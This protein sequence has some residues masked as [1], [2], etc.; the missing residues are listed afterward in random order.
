MLSLENVPLAPKVIHITLK[1][2]DVNAALFVKL[3]EQLILQLINANA[4]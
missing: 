3:Q 2:I 1:R 4:Q